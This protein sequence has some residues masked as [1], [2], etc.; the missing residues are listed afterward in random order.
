MKTVNSYRNNRGK[1]FNMVARHR[2]G[3]DV[4]LPYFTIRPHH[5]I[6]IYIFVHDNKGLWIL[7]V[8]V[9][10]VFSCFKL[11]WLPWQPDHQGG[12]RQLHVYRRDWPVYILY[13]C[14][15]LFCICYCI[16]MSSLYRFLVYENRND[17]YP[18]PMCLGAHW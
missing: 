13:I 6:H 7:I 16:F 9:V 11:S 8:C 5:M 18:F 12:H 15:Y 14:L 10:V 1:W 17:W 3:S 2:H 4:F